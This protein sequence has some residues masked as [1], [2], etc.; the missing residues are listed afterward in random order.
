MASTEF[1]VERRKHERFAARDDVVAALRSSLERKV[2]LVM[3]VSRGGL[4]FRYI[5]SSEMVAEP[6]ELDLK[7]GETGVDLKGV[8]VRLVTDTGMANEFSFSLIPLKKCS[9]QFGQMTCKQTSNLDFF[10]QYHTR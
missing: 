2:G 5:E 6:F 10:L 1:S 9:V 3:N 4:A 7:L 8:P